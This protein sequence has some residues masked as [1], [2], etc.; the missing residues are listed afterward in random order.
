MEDVLNH[1]TIKALQQNLKKLHYWFDTDEEILARMSED[2]K[3]VHN[4]MFNYVK[5]CLAILEKEQ[6]RVKAE[7]VAVE[8]SLIDKRLAEE[9]YN[10]IPN[11]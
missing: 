1:E 9:H 3:R 7:L 2:E 4:T 6:T 8:R 5:H 10:Y 11:F